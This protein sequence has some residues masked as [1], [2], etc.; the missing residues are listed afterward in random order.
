MLRFLE[1]YDIKVIKNMLKYIEYA[2]KENYKK[3]DFNVNK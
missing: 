1:I 2:N 3:M